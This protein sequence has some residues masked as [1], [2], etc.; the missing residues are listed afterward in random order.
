MDLIRYPASAGRRIILSILWLTLS[1][2]AASVASVAQRDTATAVL[3]VLPLDSVI[4]KVVARNP[5]LKMWNLRAQGRS[6][7]A[8]GAQAWM[9]PELGLGGSQLPYQGGMD[10]S[11]GD[12]AMMVSFRQMIPGFGKRA[13]QQRYLTSLSKKEWAEGKWM[14]AK[15][16]ADAKSQYYRMVTTTKKQAALREAEGVMAY[17]LVVAEV[18]FKL[19]RVDMATVF[20]ARA[21]LAEFKNKRTTEETM[22]RQAVAALALLMAT[23]DETGFTADTTIRLQ[24]YATSPGVLDLESRGDLVGVDWEIK[25]MEFNLETMRRQGRPD[26]GIQFEHM[27]MFD[28][29]RRFSAMAMMTLPL[30]PWSSGMVR[31]DIG[32]MQKAI[33]SMRADKESRLL[34]AGRMASDMILMLQSESDQYRNFNEDV[35]PAYRKSLDAAMAAYQEGTGDLFRVLDTWDRWVMSRMETVEHLEKALILEAEYARESGKP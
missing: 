9:A 17:M 16:I 35:T 2:L 33:A 15:L 28:M 3:P 10:M 12:P 20:E 22:K 5:E 13:A 4:G 8:Q 18:R 21:R 32:A 6:A 30:A 7:A 26:F 11:P 29:G 19:R 31:A 24:G 27:E 1:G 23:P 25:S 14:R 34:M